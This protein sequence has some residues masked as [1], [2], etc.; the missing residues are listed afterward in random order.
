MK[1]GHEET[2][3]WVVKL[4]QKY[5]FSDSSKRLEIKQTSE[6]EVLVEF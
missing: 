5:N 1:K 6:G 4:L 2:Y 3:K